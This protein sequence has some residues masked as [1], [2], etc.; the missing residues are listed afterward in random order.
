MNYLNRE[1]AFFEERTRLI[2]I[3]TQETHP[4]F[5]RIAPGTHRYK[6]IFDIFLSFIAIV[7]ILSWLL[8][9]LAIFIKLD[10]KGP[11]FFIQKRVGAFGK[12]FSCIKLRSMVVNADANLVQAQQNDPRITRFGKFLRF[13]CLDELPQFFNV[14]IGDMSVVGPRPH[15]IK[16]C[17]EFSKLVKHYDSRNSVKPGITGIAQVKGYRGKT[18]DYFD[19]S[20]R[21]KWDMFYVR[22]SSLSLDIKIVGLTIRTTILSIYNRYAVKEKKE[23]VTSPYQ[24]DSPELLN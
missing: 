10:S 11:V 17:K 3:P 6:R 13:S 15:M 23:E 14:L 24:L 21:Y 9:I 16:D 4:D 12:I 22:N 19:V 7:F 18:E 5:I 20:H 8:P 2:S 1:T